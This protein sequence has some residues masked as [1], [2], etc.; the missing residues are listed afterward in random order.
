[1]KQSRIVESLYK[2]YNINESCK[3]EEYDGVPIY[4]DSVRGMV[5]IY[6]KEGRR[7]DFPDEDEAIEYIDGLNESYTIYFNEGYEIDEID[8]DEIENTV[9][10]ICDT[11]DWDSYP[12]I[13]VSERTINLLTSDFQYWD[14]AD[15]RELANRINR[16]LEYDYSVSLFSSTCMELELET[17]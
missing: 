8:L 2:K 15:M 17:D 5:Y 10:E 7:I 4:W 16:N 14:T 9:E 1:M 6:T 12:D 3:L 11:Y 13:I